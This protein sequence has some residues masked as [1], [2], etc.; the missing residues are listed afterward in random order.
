MVTFLQHQD[1]NINW[2]SDKGGWNSDNGALQSVNRSYGPLFDY[3]TRYIGPYHQVHHLFPKIPFYNL[4]NAHEY[5]IE[6]YPQHVNSSD[7]TPLKAY[8]RLNK[9]W[10]ENIIKKDNDTHNFYN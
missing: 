1:E 7:E 9:V 3:L 5:F 8:F 4:K 6:H 10:R 2:K